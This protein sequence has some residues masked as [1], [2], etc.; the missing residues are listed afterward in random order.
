MTVQT[1]TI[2][3]ATVLPTDIPTTCEV[4]VGIC[5]CGNDEDIDDVVMMLV[6]NVV[7]VT[8]TLEGIVTPPLLQQSADRLRK[9]MIAPGLSQLGKASPAGSCVWLIKDA[10]IAD[11]FNQT[12]L[13]KSPSI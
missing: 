1:S 8:L 12:S 10:N 13:H 5:V 6:V 11:A 3:T 2:S 7:D 9:L 4:V